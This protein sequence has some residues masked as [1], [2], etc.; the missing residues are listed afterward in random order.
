L[1]KLFLTEKQSVSD[2]FYSPRC[3]GYNKIS[4]RGL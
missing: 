1:K 3:A 4:S 2:G